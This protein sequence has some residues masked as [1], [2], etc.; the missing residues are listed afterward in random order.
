MQLAHTGDNGLTSLFVG[1]NTE[2]RIF[3]CQLYK[4]IAHLVLACFCLWFDSDID[5]WLWEFHGFQNYWMLF[6]TDSITSCGILE[7]NSCSNIT[8]VYTIKLVSLV[9]M[10]LKDTSYTLL[11]TLGSIQY[12]RTGCQCTRV[13]TEISQLTNEWVSHDLECKSSKWL[14]VRRVTLNLIAVQVNTLNRRNV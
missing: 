6:I 3:F 7:T 12:V 5:N 1:T 9:C 4:S 13:N 14:F 8:R 2:S 11:L 10:H